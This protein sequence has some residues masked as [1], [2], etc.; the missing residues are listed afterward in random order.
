[1]SEKR[2]RDSKCSLYTQ[3]MSLS[4]RPS[5]SRSLGVCLVSLIALGGCMPADLGFPADTVRRLSVDSRV[6]HLHE[7][8]APQS[9]NRGASWSV[10]FLA[11]AHE[12]S[13]PART[14]TRRTGGPGGGP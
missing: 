10:V 9:G 6:D 12:K 1:M 8:P 4:Q 11:T 3:T 5:R 2:N 14:A 7:A 13:G